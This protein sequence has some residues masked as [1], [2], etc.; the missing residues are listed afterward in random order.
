MF[1]NYVLFLTSHTNATQENNAFHQRYQNVNHLSAAQ[2]LSSPYA[3]GGRAIKIWEQGAGSKFC[4]P[5]FFKHIPFSA[6]PPFCFSAVSRNT[7]MAAY[8]QS[9]L[10]YLCCAP[11]VVQKNK[12]FRIH[13]MNGVLIKSY[14]QCCFF[15]FFSLH[16]V[17]HTAVFSAGL[18]STVSHQ[19]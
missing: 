16:P 7:V 6:R 5:S 8:H 14:L 4:H 18:L 10:K 2:S 13:F 15:F 3:P 12:H 1:R 11:L 9:P 19:V 17:F